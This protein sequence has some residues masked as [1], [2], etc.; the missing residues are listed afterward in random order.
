SHS[1]FAT[2]VLTRL[3]FDTGLLTYINAGH[4]PPVLLRGGRA[5]KQLTGGRRLP[6]GLQHMSRTTARPASATE[7]LEPGDRLL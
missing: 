3:E 2:A 4:P 7:R 1:R 6:L 5:A